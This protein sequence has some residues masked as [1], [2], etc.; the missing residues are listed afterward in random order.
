MKFFC[1]WCQDIGFPAAF[2]ARCTGCGRL[3]SVEPERLEGVL[4]RFCQVLAVTVWAAQFCTT[5]RRP[6][7][8]CEGG[9]LCEIYSPAW[10]IRVA[11]SHGIPWEAISWKPVTM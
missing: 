10:W 8:Q 11:E 9:I 3:L 2:D 6:H 1:T 7:A 4:A 5:C